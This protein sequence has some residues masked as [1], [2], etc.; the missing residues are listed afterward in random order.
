MEIGAPK[1][2]CLAGII[3]GIKA[4]RLLIGAQHNVHMIGIWMLK[5]NSVCPSFLLCGMNSLNLG[6]N[7]MVSVLTLSKKKEMNKLCLITV[8]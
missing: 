2:T 1:S 8:I 4:T 5:H 6:K 7:Q 3:S